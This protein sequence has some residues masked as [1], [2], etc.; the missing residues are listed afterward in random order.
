MWIVKKTNTLTDPYFLGVP[1]VD[2]AVQIAK[3]VNATPILLEEAPQ[4][5]KD[6][7]RGV[8]RKFVLDP[9]GLIRS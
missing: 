7:D 8:S 5:Y 6:F 4:G 1:E 9:H 2:A 3:A